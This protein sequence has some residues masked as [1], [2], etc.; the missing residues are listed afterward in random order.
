M[1]Q[2]YLI[3]YLGTLRW[4]SVLAFIGEKL[5]GFGNNE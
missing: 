1:S 2:S 5:T 4:A 3:D